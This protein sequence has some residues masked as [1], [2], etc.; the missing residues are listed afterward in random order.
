M[1]HNDDKN[2]VQSKKSAANHYLLLLNKLEEFKE[3][4]TM[5]QRERILELVKQGIISTEEALILLEN[6]AKKEGKEAI[7]K[8]QA[9]TQTEEQKNTST[10]SSEN[11][12]ETQ[13]EESNNI[14]EFPKSEEDVQNGNFSK[15][16]QK[17]REQLEKILERLSNEA[18]SYSVKL[19]EK[20]LEIATI[21]SKLRLIQEKLMVLETKEDLEE[22]NAEKLPEMKQMKNE[23]NELKA[24]LEDLEED[25]AELENQLKTVKRKQWGTQKKQI[26]EKFEIPEDW[27]ETMDETLNQVTGRVVDTGNQFGKFMK[28]TFSTVME[29]MDW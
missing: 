7:K 10:V 26:S 13:F 24:Q 6:A 2:K 16:E 5:K 12:E 20:N 11:P 21:K 3:E 23:V 25:K 18:S 29:S 8:E 22:L 1:T 28:N 15:E 27:K 14:P 4:L 17:D 9:Y 19:D